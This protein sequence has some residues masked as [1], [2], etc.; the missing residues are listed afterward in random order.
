MQALRKFGGRRHWGALV[1]ISVAYALAMQAL[2]ASVGFGMSAM[3]VSGQDGT[4]LCLHAPDSPSTTSHDNDKTP[5][6][7][8]QCLFCF[9][10]A[11]S[12]CPTAAAT[13]VPILPAYAGQPLAGQLAG[14]PGGHTYI[15]QFQR[16]LGDPRAPPR[17]SI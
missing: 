12:S 2:L 14:D 11:Q 7:R 4:V 5:H 9:I 6:P 13:S 3:V 17:F 15:P 16:T 10:S 8:P 1:S